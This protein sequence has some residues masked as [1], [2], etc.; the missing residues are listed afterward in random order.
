MP[1]KAKTAAKEEGSEP[2]DDPQ[3]EKFARLMSTGDFSQL[4]AYTECGYEPH[5]GNASRLRGNERV[6]ARIRFFQLASADEFTMSQ[7]FKR[8]YLRQVVESPID[9]VKGNSRLCQSVKITD[10]GVEYKMP[11]KLDAI[12]IDNEMSGDNK[13]KELKISGEITIDA[14]EIIMRLSHGKD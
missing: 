8:R 3:Q 14:Q 10:D 12:K 11:G 5:D 4:Q 2:L 6:A 7:N 9:S 1:A 13:P